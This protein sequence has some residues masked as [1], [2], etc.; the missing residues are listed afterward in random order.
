M[1]QT[2]SLPQE[3]VDVKQRD[4]EDPVLNGIIWG[5]FI[6]VFVVLGGTLVVA[7]GKYEWFTYG[8]GLFFW[9]TFL[10]AAVIA[11]FIHVISLTNFLNQQPSQR[12]D[13]TTA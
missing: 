2:L 6:A 12:E 4:M 9:N 1:N 11:L 7:S 3:N 10:T 5:I 13:A 8:A